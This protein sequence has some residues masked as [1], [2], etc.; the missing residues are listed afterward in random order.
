[1]YDFGRIDLIPG[2]IV[3]TGDSHDIIDEKRP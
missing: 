3:T 1:M 2:D